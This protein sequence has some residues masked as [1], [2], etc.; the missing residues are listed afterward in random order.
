MIDPNSPDAWRMALIKGFPWD[1]YNHDDNQKRCEAAEAAGLLTLEPTEEDSN[2]R[3]EYGETVWRLTDLGK[4]LYQDAHVPAK[5][6]A[7]KDPP[8][9]LSLPIRLCKYDKYDKRIGLRDIHDGNAFA[10]IDNDD[11]PEGA[12]LARAEF[13]VRAVNSY[14]LDTSKILESAALQER[15]DEDA[16][17]KLHAKAKAL[18]KALAAAAAQFRRY[19]SLHRTRS[20][21]PAC[22]NEQMEAAAK[23]METNKKF[24][25]MCDAALE[26]YSTS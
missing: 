11:V 1:P 13:L 24:A 12:G 10:W 19:E 5:A 4:V 25:D 14:G 3:E 23:K 18:A 17:N 21:S 22:D 6:I 15:T 20:T 9:E 7:V 26:D 8:I 2:D 16:F